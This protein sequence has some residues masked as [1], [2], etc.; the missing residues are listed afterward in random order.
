ML[1]DLKKRIATA[2]L[3]GMALA[4]PLAIA[5]GVPQLPVTS[6][7]SEP[8]QIVGTINA[9]IN[10]LNGNG[11]GAGG[12]ATQPN[13]AVSLGT[14]LTGSV[15][16]PGPLVLASYAQRGIATFTAATVAG[17]ANL[18]VSITDP[19]ITTASVCNAWLVTNPTAGA[20]PTVSSVV[21]TANTLTIQLTNATSTT[22]GSVTLGVGFNC[23]Q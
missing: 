2:L 16:S 7:Y 3:L 20:G 14:F 19:G 10:Q 8:S 15:A 13:S 6:Q 4:A 18:S 5:G 22:T 1:R 12:Y 17:N 21:P 11:T 23:I 9:L